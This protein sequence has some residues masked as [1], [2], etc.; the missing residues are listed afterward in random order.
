MA[1]DPN[2]KCPK[3]EAPAHAHGKGGKEKC[4]ETYE[5]YCDGFICE[6]DEEC[7]NAHGTE[8]E[9]CQNAV[10]YHCGWFGAFPAGMVRCKHCKGTGLVKSRKA[11]KPEIK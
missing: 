10:C 7:G 1:I 3:C 6:C 9:P 5:T 8:E 4:N 11:K 2:W